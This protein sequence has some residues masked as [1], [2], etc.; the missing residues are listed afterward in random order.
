MRKLKNSFFV[1][2]MALMGFYNN[3]SAQ[4]ISVPDWENPGLTTFNTV[5]PHV[6][7]VPYD[8]EAQAIKNDPKASS[9]YLL[10]NGKW[11][12]KLSDNYTQVPAGFYKPGF[13]AS[14]W[15]MLDVPSTWEV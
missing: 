10:L 12:F 15:G 11:K 8:N 4:Q 2:A 5:R 6:T 1:A 3:T 14:S 9:A 13:D 7:Y